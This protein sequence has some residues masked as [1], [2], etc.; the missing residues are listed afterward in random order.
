[1]SFVSAFI[2][3]D[4]ASITS[5]GKVTGA[6][7]ETVQEDYKK[8]IKVN[9]FL[10]GFTGNST[11]PV[12]LIKAAIKETSNVM[13]QEKLNHALILNIIIKCLDKYTNNAAIK[14]NI[15]LVGFDNGTP[16]INT[17]NLNQLEV[18]EESFEFQERFRLITL[19]PFD[20][21]LE[22]GSEVAKFIEMVRLLD[23]SEINL[24]KI[25]EIQREINNFVADNSDTVNKC[26]FTEY[27]KNDGYLHA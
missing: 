9:S 26:T 23:R 27:L 19:C 6:N 5:D 14:T 8:I 20:Y 7:K 15:I 16:V 11:A 22:N 1:M 21:R 4:F 24:T 25:I 2:T 3:S 18:T 12:E 13:G 17:I 10:I